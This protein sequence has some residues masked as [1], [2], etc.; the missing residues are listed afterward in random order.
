MTG[1]QKFTSFNTFN[2]N[3]QARSQSSGDR[4]NWKIA[5]LY[6]S[7]MSKCNQVV[8]CFALL[9]LKALTS[10]QLTYGGEKVIGWAVQDGNL[11]LKHN[12]V[13][14]LQVLQV[15]S[16]QELSAVTESV[17]TGSPL[18]AAVRKMDFASVATHVWLTFVT[19][20]GRI[21]DLDLSAFQFGTMEPFPCIAEVLSAE[22]TAFN[23]ICDR[24]RIMPSNLPGFRDSIMEL[25]DIH[26]NMVNAN[27]G[28]A[29]TSGATMA[30]NYT[31]TIGRVLEQTARGGLMES[32]TEPDSFWNELKNLFDSELN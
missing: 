18:P 11:K 16:P 23:G 2:N 9:V 31:N 19:E 6:M 12:Q 15:S 13:I 7:F 28:S 26:A 21:F 10:H 4:E 27:R 17:R 24:D 5:Y 20:S 8:C 1:N 29:V 22:S 32:F 30:S 25:L 3:G 14:E